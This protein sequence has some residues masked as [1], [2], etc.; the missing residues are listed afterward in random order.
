MTAIRELRI[1]PPLAVGRLGAAA[2]PM[3]NYTVEVDPRNQQTGTD[4]YGDP[5]YE[6]VVRE[7]ADEL[8]TF[9]GTP[10]LVQA[11]VANKDEARGMVKKV[12]ELHGERREAAPSGAS[13][14][15]RCGISAASARS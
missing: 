4:R 11:D 14:R 15:P 3:D 1:L 7:V 13:S 6:D 12:A 2:E 5:I 8:A 9:G 10:M